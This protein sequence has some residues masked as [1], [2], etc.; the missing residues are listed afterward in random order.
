MLGLQ[1]ERACSLL[2]STG[3]ANG[4]RGAQGK[5]VRRALLLNAVP[6]TGGKMTMSR[7]KSSRG[8]DAT[9]HSLPAA[10][11]RLHT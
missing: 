6:G 9:V 4:T 7:C 1:V 8:R 3:I 10:V 2:V 11:T 5:V